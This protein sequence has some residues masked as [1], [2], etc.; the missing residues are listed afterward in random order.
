MTARSPRGASKPS[1]EAS[2]SGAAL[3]VGRQ[4]GEPVTQDYPGESPHRFTGGTIS[5]VAVDVSGEPYADLRREAAL[6]A[7]A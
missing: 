7:D 2:P 5:W 1:S 6:D 3:T 4:S